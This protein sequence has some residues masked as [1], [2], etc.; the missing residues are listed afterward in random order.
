MTLLEKAVE[1]ARSF[2]SSRNKGDILNETEEALIVLSERLQ[3]LERIRAR[4]RQMSGGYCADR[5]CKERIQ[6]LESLLGQHGK[7]WTAVADELGGCYGG[8]D[9]PTKDPH[10]T[11]GVIVARIKALKA[12]LLD[13]REGCI[14]AYDALLALPNAKNRIPSIRATMRKGIE[15]ADAL[16]VNHGAPFFPAKS[17]VDV[18][19]KACE[20]THRLTHSKDCDENGVDGCIC[21]KG[22]PQVRN[23][24]AKRKS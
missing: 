24:S 15:G 1:R 2:K 19:I 16:G 6:N 12:A 7:H 13:A 11:G 22:W 5:D 3:Y 17:V 23:L 9:G 4:G 18:L 8:V 10:S 21:G 14:A 20:K